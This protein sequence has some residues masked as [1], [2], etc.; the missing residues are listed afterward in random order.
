MKEKA[1]IVLDVEPELKEILLERLAACRKNLK[2]TGFLKLAML[3]LIML[4]NQQLE[5]FLNRSVLDT[6]VY[7]SYLRAAAKSGQDGIWPAGL[8][9]GNSEM[10]R[11]RES[12]RLYEQK[13]L[14]KAEFKKELEKAKERN[15]SNNFH[16]WESL[17]KYIDE[18]ADK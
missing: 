8:P 9:V 13:K 17:A 3:R 18:Y 1:R 2:M 11:I 16:R 6:S 7:E 5:D 14:T 10:L 4:D 12:F 15:D